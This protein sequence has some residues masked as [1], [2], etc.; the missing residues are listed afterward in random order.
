[1]AAVEL[2]I[3]DFIQQM[4]TVWLDYIM[5]FIT[6]L[7]EGGLVWIAAGML[8]LASKKHRKTGFLI[9]AALAVEILLCNGI[10]KPLAQRV[11]PCDMRQGIQL[12]VARPT[13]YSFPSGHTGA[14]FA[15]AAVLWSRREKGRYIGVILAA[16]IAFSRMYLYVHYPTDI[17]GGVIIGCTSGLFACLC[18]NLFESKYGKKR[19]ITV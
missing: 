2:Q 10:L 13:D 14:S 15:A 8:L 11:R 17:L 5:V 9:L 16:L 7:G 3:L 18:L 6:T 19:K 1:M 12:L 4:R